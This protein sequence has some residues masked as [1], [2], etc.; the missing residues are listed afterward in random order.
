MSGVAQSSRRRNDPH[1]RLPLATT[2]HSKGL[3]LLATAA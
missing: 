2:A 3:L 1:M